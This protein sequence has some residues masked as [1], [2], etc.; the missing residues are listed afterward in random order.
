MP[1]PPGQGLLLH[2][3][4]ADILGDAHVETLFERAGHCS[5]RAG[6]RWGGPA[7]EPRPGRVPSHPLARAGTSPQREVGHDQLPAGAS[8]LPR[9]LSRSRA[10]SLD[11]PEHLLHQ[12]MM[13]IAR[14][15]ARALPGRTAGSRPSSRSLAFFDS[16][17]PAG[18]KVGILLEAADPCP[19]GVG[20]GPSPR[21]PKPG[22]EIEKDCGS[23]AGPSGLLSRSASSSPPGPMKPS[24]QSVA[25]RRI[26]RGRPMRREGQT[27]AAGSASASGLALGAATASQAGAEAATAFAGRALRRLATPFAE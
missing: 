7:I 23:P 3:P 13:E 20:D 19:P 8:A 11:R 10:L 25:A 27:E 22:A 6:A 2:V 14:A 4:G 15:E 9:P 12:G 1:A 21:R 24:P 5:A 26:R 18:S 16:A 17:S